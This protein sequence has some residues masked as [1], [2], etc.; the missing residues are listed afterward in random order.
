MLIIN[1]APILRI[2]HCAQ[3]GYGEAVVKRAPNMRREFGA[4]PIP[5]FLPH[6]HH[7]RREDSRDYR[8]ARIA[9]RLAWYRHI[10]S[11]CGSSFG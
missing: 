9:A 11:P 4:K 1:P 5:D 2:Q 6:R 10:Y 3:L 7:L 8:Q